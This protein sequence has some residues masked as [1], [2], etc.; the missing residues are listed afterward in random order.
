MPVIPRKTEPVLSRRDLSRRDFLGLVSKALLGM[1]ALLGV[2]VLVRFLDY[3]N[4][5]TRPTDFDLG[6]AENYASGSRTVIADA[7]AV[8]L[9]TERGFLA[10]STICPHLGCTVEST[11]DGFVCPCH[12]SRFDRQGALLHG[13]ATH[14]LTELRVEQTAQGR[15]ILH[16]D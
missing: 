1:S 5:A 6:P 11:V 8:L 7:Q 15:L 12:I 14:S 10:L 3:Q 13:P 4:E 2:G 16:T 9:H